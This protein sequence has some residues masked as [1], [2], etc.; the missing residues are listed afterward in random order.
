MC[1][2][3]LGHTPLPTERGQQ[4]PSWP[5][6]PPRVRALVE[7][8]LGQPVAEAV[9]QGGG[10]TNGFASRLLLADGSRVFVKA[11]SRPRS[12]EIFSSYQQEILVA[13]ALPE[14]VPATKLRWVLEQE[15][16]LMLAFDDVAGRTPQ[17]PWQPNELRA[18]LDM[19]TPLATAMTP[20]PAGLPK[21]DR[22]PTSTATFP[23]GAGFSRE[24]SAPTRSSLAPA[25]S[26]GWRT[27]RPW[28]A[29]GPSW[30]LGRLPFTSTC[31]TTTC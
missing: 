4:R 7:E 9:S 13:R 6:L 23:S 12:P 21:L 22:P 24:M 27:S 28:R 31:E 25:G 19:L 1:P 18:V 10:F 16:W 15:D 3:S 8:R 26:G 14:H 5:S 11:V 29:T 20:A 17:R 30:P 2:P